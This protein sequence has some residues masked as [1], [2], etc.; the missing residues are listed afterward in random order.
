MATSSSSDVDVTPRGYRLLI[1]AFLDARDALELFRADV[2]AEP[3][4]ATVVGYR[5]GDP[6]PDEQLIDDL[7]SVPFP[8]VVTA[9]G[10]LPVNWQR[11]ADVVVSEG[12][13]SLDD[14]VANLERQPIAAA[15]LALLL[16]QQVGLGS[17]AHGLIAESA[18]YSTLQGGA[19]FA[20]WREGRIPKTQNDD[21]PRVR[22][23]REG[24]ILR[25]T[26]SRPDRLN[27]LDVRMRDELLEALRVPV[28]DPTIERVVLAGEGRSFCAG[29][30]LDE[31]GTRSDPASAHVLRLRRHVGR[32]L[33]G[34][35]GR[36]TTHLHG[37]V[38]G[39]GIEL[40][41]FAETVIA[42]QD[43]TI[44][45]PEITMGLVPGAGGTVSLPR[46][47]GRLRTAWLALSGRAIDA[48]T[49]HQWGLVDHVGAGDSA[50][51]ELC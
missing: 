42:R 2:I 10:S 26:L 9:S 17:V 33:Y 25:I 44:S 45:L 41:A 36:L 48:D 15:T 47:I 11:L 29:G 7:A 19:E 51:G 16:R 20:R 27:A 6:V 18:A 38:A 21:E 50:N 13:P 39:S 30:D 43:T 12:D 46:R 40:A 49:A 28:A 31:F 8:I 35:R 34:L 14:I 23:E 1:P 24:A 22:V 4:D 5:P 3:A 37:P 32:V